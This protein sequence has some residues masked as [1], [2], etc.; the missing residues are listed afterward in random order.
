L[1]KKYLLKN[2]N[3]IFATDM[4]SSCYRAL[5]EKCDFFRTEATKNTL[6]ANYNQANALL[7]EG[8]HHCKGTDAQIVR[9]QFSNVGKMQ[10]FDEKLEKGARF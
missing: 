5:K 9:A 8:L 7:T 3:D 6:M 4:L 2:P 10:E 1:L